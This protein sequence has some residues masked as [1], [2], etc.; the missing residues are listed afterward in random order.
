MTSRSKAVVKSAVKTFASLAGSMVPPSSGSRILLYH[1]VG[2]RDHE[3]NVTPDAFRTQMA[4]LAGQCTPITLLQ[5]LEGRDGVAVT[6]DDGYLDNLTEAAPILLEYGIPA[7]VYVVAGR[8]GGFL[9]HDSPDASARLMTWDQVREL[10]SMGVTIGAHTLTHA[11]LS[12]CSDTR[13]HNEIV[14]CARTMEDHLQH[15]IESFAYPF[16]TSADFD[17]RS[18]QLVRDAGYQCACS[19]RYGVNVSGRRD[20]WA[21]RRIWIDRS[22][23]QEVFCRKVSGGLDLLRVLDSKPALLARKILNRNLSTHR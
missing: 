19:A 22:D 16:G 18:R 5:A 13:Q 12:Q 6:F 17:G 4:W 10:E 7:T 1:S 8:L 14:D 21:L 2:R 11:R 23:S 3:M 9:D 20:P 15:P